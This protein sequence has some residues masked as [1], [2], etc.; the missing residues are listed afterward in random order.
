[1]PSPS[2][3]FSELASVALRKHRKELIDQISKN[4][5]LLNRLMAK[6]R[7]RVEDGGLSIAMPLEY[8]ENQTYQRFSGYDILNIAPSDIITTAEFPWRQIAIHVSASGEELRKNSG[9]TRIINL[10][11]AK[12]RNATKTFK[13]QFSADLYSDGTLANQINGLQA[14][15]PSTGQGTVG[16]IDS[17]TWAFW[18]TKVQ[19]AAA[20]IGGGAALTLTSTD[21]EKLFLGLWMELS[22]GNESPDLIVVD[23]ALYAAFEN[24]QLPQKRYTNSNTAQGGFM[25]LKYKSAD[26]I[27]D[28][29]SGIPANV[30]YMLNTDYI[31]LVV[32][33]DAD[34]TQLDSV[35]PL[36][37]DAAITPMIWMGNLVISN[38]SRQGIVKA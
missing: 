23:N 3:V 8:A 27:F 11:K 29:G 16:G 22:V 15:V 31:E 14:L 18:R 21:I 17:A 24:S 2:A 26:V 20:P 10:V 28:G 30:A 37:Q 25:S 36:Q 35:R 33:K 13:N 34:L 38:R 32:H 9:D 5:A 12:V 6:G 7:K 4:N 19:S 1:M